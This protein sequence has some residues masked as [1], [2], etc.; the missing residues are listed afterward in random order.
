MGFSRRVKPGENFVVDPLLL[1]TDLLARHKRDIQTGVVGHPF[2]PAPTRAGISAHHVKTLLSEHLLE[3]V[4]KFLT[5][6]SYMRLPIEQI[7]DQFL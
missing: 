3:D 2:V 1:F 4:L 7:V 6:E 5:I